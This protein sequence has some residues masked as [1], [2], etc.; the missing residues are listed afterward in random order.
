MGTLHGLGSAAATGAQASHQLT[1][2]AL[3]SDPYPVLVLQGEHYHRCCGGSSGVRRSR[4]H[5]PPGPYDFDFASSPQPAA[6]SDSNAL[7]QHPQ[8]Q[9]STRAP[10]LRHPRLSS[11][12][13]RGLAEWHR[14]KVSAA[15]TATCYLCQLMCVLA[16]VCW[17]RL[18]LNSARVWQLWRCRRRHE[19][20]LPQ[21]RHLRGRP[22]SDMDAQQL[23]LLCCWGVL[24][25]TSS[26]AQSSSGC[27][28]RCAPGAASSQAV[29]CVG[30]LRVRRH[31]QDN[32]A[33]L[34]RGSH[35]HKRSSLQG[36]WPGLRVS[37]R[38]LRLS[39]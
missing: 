18:V 26:V 12:P 36:C 33:I 14:H 22:S 32:L 10:Q 34:E 28:E 3:L 27:S 4:V 6:S 30:L 13:P 17:S 8:S 9:H 21:L 11:H 16:P 39:G 35:Q 19:P 23:P 2:L 5:S 15:T 31:Q 7:T 20:I 1:R 38:H 24:V 37:V 29:L 25:N